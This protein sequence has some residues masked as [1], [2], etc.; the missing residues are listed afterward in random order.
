MSILQSIPLTLRNAVIQLA[1]LS[2]FAPI[3]TTASLHN[4]DLLKS[5][6]ATHVIDRTL[7]PET[8]AQQAREIA[9]GLIDLVYD[10]ISVTDTLAA[11]YQATSP[12]GDFVVVLPEPIPGAD[13]NSQ[14]KVHLAHGLFHTP[15][16]RA[17]GKNLL[18]KLPELLEKG[19]IKVSLESSLWYFTS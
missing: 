4:S 14:K 1:R 17:S 18:A 8:V 12:Q 9:G 2:G 5:F 10:A 13:A 19:D 3:I 16:N 6:G 11:G 7:S 15:I